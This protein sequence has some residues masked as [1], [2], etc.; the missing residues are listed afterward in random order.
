MKNNEN[1]AIMLLLISTA[2]LTALLISIYS[3]TSQPAFADAAT[4]AGDYTMATG[5]WDDQVDLL[6]VI[7]IG[8]QKLNAY[9]VNIN[10]SAIEFRDSVDLTKVFR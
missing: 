10:T 1:S 8:A 3:N 6:Y 7:D 9:V 4:R 5:A 2:I